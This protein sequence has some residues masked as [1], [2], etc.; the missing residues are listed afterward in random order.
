VSR[1]L[2]R[3]Q[4]VVLGFVLVAGLGLAGVGIFAVGSG[5]WFW[6]DS[7]H[8]RA[9]FSSVNG[10]EVG[11]RVRVRG[12]DAGEVVAL[13]PP[14]SA[15]GQVMMRVRIDK[16]FRHLVRRNA[17][18]QIVSVGML[19]GKA[20]EISPGTESEPVAADGALLQ[21]KP[22]T[23][24]TDVVEQVKTTLDSV[25]DGKGSL[26]MLA[27][28]PRAYESLVSALN[29]IRGAAGSVQADAEA[30][31]KVPLLGGYVEDP[32]A[33]LVRPGH[34]R[35]RKVF[36]ED[37]LFEPGRSVLTRQGR[38]KLDEAGRWMGGFTHSKSE[39]VVVAYADPSSESDQ[40]RTV[41]SQQSKAVLKYL[42]DNFKIHKLGIF[43]WRKTT[44]LGMG[45]NPPPAPEK[46]A[47]PAA[48]IEVQVFVPQN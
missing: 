5:K 29:S 37:E 3:L 40:A 16:Q 41:T 22:A 28:D 15:E 19:G 33:L 44:A 38:E 47:L 48:R 46:Q 1:N 4:A 26:G 32:R 30:V 20:V 14:L 13:E 17:T 6:N 24:L 43:S 42:E 27:R 11:T 31:K 12:M 9:G 25:V 23:E 35:N 7:F 21:S 2:T 45:V 36:R 39:V 34:E 8:V 10:V 18:I